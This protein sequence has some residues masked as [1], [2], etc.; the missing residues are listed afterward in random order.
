MYNF[1]MFFIF[2]EPEQEPN[3]FFFRAATD[4][5]PVFF[6]HSALAPRGQNMR[7]LAAPAPQL[8][9]EKIKIV[10]INNN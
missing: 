3:M 7:L 6:L 5:A 10:I 4:P 8:C 1:L 9:H 2:Y